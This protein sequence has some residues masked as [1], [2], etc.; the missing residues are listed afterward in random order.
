M[1]AQGNRLNQKNVN[2]LLLVPK[3]EPGICFEPLVSQIELLVKFNMKNYLKYFKINMEQWIYFKI[4]TS[5]E[6]LAY[7]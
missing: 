4:F 7:L 2:E 1:K 6:A 3:K 5:P